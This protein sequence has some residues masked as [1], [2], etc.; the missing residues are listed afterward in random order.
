MALF[1]EEPRAEWTCN[2]GSPRDG[3]GEEQCLANLIVDSLS[4]FLSTGFLCQVVGSNAVVQRTKIDM[5]RA[6][7]DH[8]GKIPVDGS[9]ERR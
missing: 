1:I 8:V 9:T 4:Q 7:A 6:E 5:A 3:L 2:P